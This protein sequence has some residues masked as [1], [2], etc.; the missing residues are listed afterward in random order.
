MTAGLGWEVR[1]EQEVGDDALYVAHIGH[2][3]ARGHVTVEA[4]GHRK[5]GG[6]EYL[7]ARYDDAGGLVRGPSSFS[8]PSHA[9]YWSRRW[10]LGE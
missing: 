6:Y 2:R 10:L 7:V 8:Y 4:S 1:T 5:A 3:D 9:A